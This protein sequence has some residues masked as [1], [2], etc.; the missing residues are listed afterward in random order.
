MQLLFSVN[1]T[2]QASKCQS[3]NFIYA[4]S[5]SQD[6][7]WTQRM[8]LE[9][10]RW[11]REEEK[12]GWRRREEQIHHSCKYI[13]EPGEEKPTGRVGGVEGQQDDVG[14]CISVHV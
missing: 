3:L 12:G 1:Q 2:L 7:L 13:S 4:A 6:C 11:L 10:N 14:R 5:V 9:M 8:R